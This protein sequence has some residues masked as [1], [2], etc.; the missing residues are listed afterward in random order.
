MP[1][2]TD[3][4]SK[5]VHNESTNDRSRQVEEVDWG[6]EYYSAMKLTQRRPAERC[7]KCT[8]RSVHRRVE[9]RT[10]LICHRGDSRAIKSKGA[11]AVSITDVD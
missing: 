9:E 11:R 3:L 2:R 8:L 6:C 7:V 5:S 4:G 1:M 10:I